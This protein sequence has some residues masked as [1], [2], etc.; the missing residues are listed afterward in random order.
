MLDCKNR[1][2]KVYPCSVQTSCV[3][4]LFCLSLVRSVGVEPAYVEEEDCSCAEGLGGG[5]SDALSPSA[6][7][8][9]AGS[10]SIDSGGGGGSQRTAAI[11]VRR[12]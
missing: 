4:I 6:S 11:T 7:S 1:K 3:S 8:P 9:Q 12:A 5:G 10:K 2:E